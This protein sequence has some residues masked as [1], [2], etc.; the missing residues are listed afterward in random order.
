MTLSN[1]AGFNVLRI[2]TF[3]L[4]NMSLQSASHA[5][6]EEVLSLSPLMT[7]NGKKRYAT[8]IS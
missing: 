3:C 5:Q 4:R 7:G 2:P 6:E 8:I 1:V